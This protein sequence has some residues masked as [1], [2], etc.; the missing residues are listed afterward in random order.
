MANFADE[1]MFVAEPAEG[2]SPRVTLL[3]APSDPLG[4]LAQIA[5][6]YQG[7]ARR[8]LAE[9]SDSDRQYYIKD[10]EKNVLG[11]PSEAIQFHFLIENVTRSFT[12]QLV[13]TR[14]ASYAQ[15]SLRF[16]VKE[17]FPVGL[18]PSLSGT[19]HELKEIRND[20]RSRFPEWMDMPMRVLWEVPNGLERQE[21]ASREWQFR[22]A[23]VSKE[24]AWR[25]VWDSAISHLEQ[26]YKEL[27]DK[28]MPAEDARGLLPHAILTKVNM[29][30]NLRSLMQMAGQRLCTQAQFEHRQVWA[31]IL[32]A[33]REYGKE[34]HYRTNDP[35]RDGGVT[36]MTEWKDTDPW[37]YALTET[38]D[39]NG[40]S[41][42]ERSSI[43]QFETLIARF[44]PVC[45]QTGRC[46]FRSDFDRYCNIRDRVEANAAINRPSSE[47]HNDYFTMPIQEIR[48]MD[49]VVM[50]R[51]MEPKIDIPA[52]HPAEWLDPRAAIRP[53]G[54]WRTEEAKKNIEGRRL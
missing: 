30:I 15:E 53:D 13:R 22:S 35:F 33:L 14:Q 16:A 29:V 43:W 3:D 46:Q 10:M 4:K 34:C 24:N 36:P 49:E 19:R 8:S 32:Q 1:S 12:H 38:G 54:E 2:L 41:S 52:I 6:M 23:R 11:M 48:S 25:G 40:H 47:W 18:P 7:K 9:I 39:S 45:Y 21:A 50:T 26:A 5:Q 37:A 28:G 44:Q 42:Y 17:D 31:G 20:I 51:P 27:I